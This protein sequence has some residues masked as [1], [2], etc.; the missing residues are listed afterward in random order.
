MNVIG[1]TGWYDALKADERS[2][3]FDEWMEGAFRSWPRPLLGRQ[4]FNVVPLAEVLATVRDPNA[5]DCEWLL[6]ITL[7]HRIVWWAGKFVPA[8]EGDVERIAWEAARAGGGGFDEGP[9]SWCAREEPCHCGGRSR[10][11]CTCGRCLYPG[12]LPDDGP[13][14]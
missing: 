10:C 14:P 11:A 9:C 12:R 6:V 1:D 3:A 13:L 4:V 2:R 5:R 8:F 7:P